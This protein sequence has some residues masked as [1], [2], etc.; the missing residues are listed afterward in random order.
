MKKVF[1]ITAVAG[2]LAVGCSSNENSGGT[3][4]HTGASWSSDS[5]TGDMTGSETR[6]IGTEMTPD[7]S[8]TL[9]Q[10]QQQQD[11]STL[12]AT[13]SGTVESGQ[14]SY[15]PTNNS[16]LPNSSDRPAAPGG[17]D[18]GADSSSGNFNTNSNTNN[19]DGDLNQDSTSRPL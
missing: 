14:S 12:D 7:H 3:Y 5:S 8:S 6:G 11:S 19:A 4:D 13:T 17:S 15:S 2:L 1:A 16:A 9:P 18:T 10:H